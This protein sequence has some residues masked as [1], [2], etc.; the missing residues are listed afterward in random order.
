[1]RISNQGGFSLWRYNSGTPT[2]LAGFAYSATALWQKLIFEVDGSDINIKV[3]ISGESEP[4]FQIEHIDG[5]PLGGTGGFQLCHYSISGGR[6]VRIDEVSLT[7][8]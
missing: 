1:M 4:A 8:P 2:Y 3:W 7:T 6:W 5:S